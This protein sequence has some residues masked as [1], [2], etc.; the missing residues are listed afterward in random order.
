MPPARHANLLD[1]AIAHHRQGRLAQAGALYAQIQRADTANFAAFHLGGLIALQLERAA[2]ALPQLKTA[3]RLDPRHALNHHCLG[4]ALLK[5]GQ[6]PEAEAAFL[7]SLQLE[8]K[9]GE[10]W[11]NLGALRVQQGK[12]AEAEDAYR[13]GLACNAKDATLWNGLGSV[14]LLSGDPLEALRCQEQA[15][16]LDAKHPQ[17]QVGRAQALF[18]LN[19]TAEAER[20]FS[21]HLAAHPRDLVAA[22][23]RLLCL[24]YLDSLSPEQVAREHFAF[25]RLAAAVVGAGA[26]GT[27][28]PTP[29]ATR[30]R[31]GFVSPDFRRHSV[32]TF[33]EPLLATLD[34]SRFELTLYH[35][36]FAEDVVTRRFKAL[37]DRWR[38]VVGLDDATVARL[39]RDDAIEVLVDLCGHTGF[40]R[41]GLF[42][43]RVA[44][45]QVT[46]LGY[47]NTT[48]LATMDFRF[49]DDVT[50]PEGE[51]DSHYSEKRIRFSPCAWAYLPPAEAPEPGRVPDGRVRFGSFNAANKLSPATLRCWAALLREVPE[52][53]LLL[54]SSGMVPERMRARAAE[55]GIPLDRL[56]I[57][58]P[59]AGIAEHLA[60]YR[61][62]DVALDPFPY[63][64][65]T[66]TCEALWMGVPVV[67]LYGD[68]HAARVGASLLSAIGRKD[69]IAYSE[70]EYIALAASLIKGA[71]AQSSGAS[72]ASGLRGAA[73]RETVR[74][75][76]LLDHLG[77]ARAFENALLSC[78]RE[79]LPQHH[80]LTPQ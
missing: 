1:Q 40:N 22:S 13:K 45:V 72:T 27:P 39:V 31:V 35:D 12:L 18:Q 69:W 34:R 73:L 19:E 78:L 62:L 20:A 70:P 63:N 21:N 79:R 25:G 29:P 59:T 16:T 56:E 28:S 44:P 15:L 2:D 60:L 9:N 24:N 43:R 26:T 51:G 68:R 53:T 47:P 61:T 7:R 46:Y 65:T 54:K 23:Q 32:A 10:A 6:R 71:S 3:A 50:D 38:P 48:G 14:R 37:A 66:T 5:L 75:S 57:L 49:V 55:A 52:A 30:V 67:T 80:G 4:T 8:P 33:L 36:H 41:M 17:A 11:G 77:Q 76:R 74:N 42:A 64:G 58:G